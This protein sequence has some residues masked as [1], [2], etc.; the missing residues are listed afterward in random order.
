MTELGLKHISTF[1]AVAG[2]VFAI[3]KFIHVQEIQAATP[4]LEKKLKWCEEA[5]VT[6]STVA[7]SPNKNEEDIQKFWTLYWGVMGM[8]EKKE[9]ECAM[10]SFGDA[11]SSD[12][13]KNSDGRRDACSNSTAATVTEDPEN[14][15]TGSQNEPDNLKQKALSIAL[16]C[17]L[18]LAQD[19]SSK[20]LR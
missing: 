5:V 8:I 4:Y 20:W 12:G 15:K 17:R 14:L 13:Y 6:A 9:I 2:C 10:I 3:I 1:V 16:A 19:W 18:E 11:L 7:N